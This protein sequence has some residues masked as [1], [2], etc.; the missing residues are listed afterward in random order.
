VIEMA[1]CT[2]Q[3]QPVMANGK[4]HPGQRPDGTYTSHDAEV[5]GRD[6]RHHPGSGAYVEVDVRVCRRCLRD[7]TRFK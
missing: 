3:P 1:N 6:I 2:Q 4:P 7:V 5:W